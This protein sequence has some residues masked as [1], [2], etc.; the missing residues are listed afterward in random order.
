[1]NKFKD[2]DIKP[3]APGFTGDKIKIERILNREIVIHDYRI[4]D[5]K[6]NDGKG[7][8]LHLQ[9]EI[10]GIKHVVFTG[11]AALLEIVQQIPQSGFPFITTII[12]DNDRFEFT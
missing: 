1:M 4:T 5:S 6:Y 7:K 3:L 10:G 12:K 2:F 9:I 8:C 11:S